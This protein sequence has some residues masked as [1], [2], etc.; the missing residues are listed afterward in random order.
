MGMPGGMEWVLIALV[1]LLLFGGKKIPEL[2]KGLGS[3]IKNFKKAVKE[4]DEVASTDKNEEIEKKA[5][6]KTEE[7]QEK[8]TV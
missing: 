6:A 3:G 1:V 4:D 5:E 2:A 8:K 7:P